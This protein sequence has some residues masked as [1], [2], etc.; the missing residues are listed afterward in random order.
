MEAVL[1]WAVLS[2]LSVEGCRCPGKKE[3]TEH[4][5][6]DRAWVLWVPPGSHGPSPL[7]PFLS[8]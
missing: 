5:G 6:T 4:E 2:V 3:V 7:F 8:V 1:A